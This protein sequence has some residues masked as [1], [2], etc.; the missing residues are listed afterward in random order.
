MQPQLG[1]ISVKATVNGTGLDAKTANAKINAQLLSAYYNK[2][3][4]KNLLL[5]GTY[6]GQ[7]NEYQ[8]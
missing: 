4:Y 2:Y 6:S 5:S 3:T 7:K 1:R 8:K